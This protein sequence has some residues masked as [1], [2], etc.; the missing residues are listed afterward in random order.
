MECHRFRIL[1][2][3][4]HDG[5]LDAAER[6]EY[7]RHVARC[8]A[9]REL[10]RQFAAVF[11]ALDGIP[12]MEPADD[13]NA[14]VMAR[15]DVSRYRARRRRRALRTIENVWWWVPRPVR[16][17]IPVCVAFAFF[18]GVYT[19][20]LEFLLVAG[21][22]ALAFAG[23][24]LLVI[25]ELEGRSESVIEFFSSAAHYRV[26]GEVLARTAHHIAAEIPV[27]YIGLAAVALLLVFYIMVRAARIAWKKG[28]TNVG[29]F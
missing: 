13:F 7:E 28:E 20:V 29:I 15:V 10:D 2:Q 8:A 21:H 6:A 27:V 12:L 16:I 11:G 25:K 24:S 23:S 4:Y 1:L 19:P 3:R 9:C 18:A 26:A 17:A 5:E 14:R 22:R